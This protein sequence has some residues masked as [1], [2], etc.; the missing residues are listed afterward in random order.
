VQAAAP[1]QDSAWRGALC[2]VVS[3]FSVQLGAAVSAELF[4]R[5]SPISVASLRLVFAAVIIL[6]IVRPRLRA[7]REWRTIALYGAVSASLNILYFSA[8]ARLP[9]GVASSLEFLGPL[10]VGLFGARSRLGLLAPSGAFVGVVALTEP[11]AIG[12]SAPMGI[13]FG[14]GA[15]AMLGA[16]VVLTRRLGEAEGFSNLAWSITV[17]ALV[18][19][20]FGAA[21]A[22]STLTTGDLGAI[23]AGA[24]LVPLLPY[25]L[26]LVAM[27]RLSSATYS[28]LLSLEPFVAVLIGWVVLHQ[29][30]H[31]I[32]YFGVVLVVTVSIFVVTSA[33]DRPSSR[34][35]L[36]HE[37]PLE[38]HPYH[39]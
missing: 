2:G 30:L 27:R 37:D 39:P 29:N 23:A 17:A 11:W 31:P 10:V 16:Y 8:V 15:G 19:I 35:I 34:E 1:F 5:I 20:P 26:E 4:D 9:L 36:R 7:R 3:M 12:R 38:Q 13:A 22:T 32:Q 33:N 28:V 6:V 21:T 14:M 24:V 25:A 18:S